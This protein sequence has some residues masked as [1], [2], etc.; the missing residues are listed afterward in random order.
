MMSADG[1]VCLVVGGV[2]AI[3]LVIAT[4]LRESGATVLATTSQPAPAVS[5]VPVLHLDV[6][7]QSS[8]R[9]VVDRITNEYGRL[10]VLVYNPGLPGPSKPIEEIRDEEWEEVFEVNITGFFRVCRASIPLLRNSDGG[11]RIIAISSMTG[12]R[13]LLHRTSY[14]ATKMA[15]TGFVRSLALEVGKDGITVNTVSPGYVEG[16]RIKWVINAQAEAQGMTPEEVRA[17]VV[18][19]SPVGRFVAPESIG[20]TV[21]FLADRDARDITGTDINVTGGVWMD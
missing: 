3:G 8:I 2:R 1:R 19:Q 20:R 9:D 17:Q 11:G 21:L 13:P 5:P 18:A 6:R 16:E 4:C 7:D 14:A 10:D 12:R 15:L